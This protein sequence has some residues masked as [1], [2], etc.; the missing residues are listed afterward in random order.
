MSPLMLPSQE[1]SLNF[2]HVCLRVQVRGNEIHSVTYKERTYTGSKLIYVMKNC[3]K[4]NNNNTGG[5][6]K[7]VKK[8]VTLE[9]ETVI[10]E[11]FNKFYCFLSHL[12]I[13][14]TKCLSVCVCVCIC[15]CTL[16]GTR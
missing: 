14:I 1:T 8:K 7:L 5:K 15:M 3:L 10:D 13:Q 9:W 12:Y 11:R 4:N 6:E 2:I 16:I